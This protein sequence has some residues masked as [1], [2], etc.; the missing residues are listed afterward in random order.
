ML[1]AWALL[2][3]ASVAKVESSAV[4]KEHVQMYEYKNIYTFI[5]YRELDILIAQEFICKSLLRT[6]L[7]V[8]SESCRKT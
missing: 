2:P 6:M 8:Q 4:Y 3:L 1:S 5:T 7:I